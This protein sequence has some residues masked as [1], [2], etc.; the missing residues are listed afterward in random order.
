MIDVLFNSGTFKASYFKTVGSFVRRLSRWEKKILGEVE[1][2]IVGDEVIQILNKEYRGQ[3]RVTDV[4]SFAWQEDKK[5]SS[6]LLGQIFICYPQIKRQAKDYKVS[7]ES[8]FY[9]MLIHGLL[10]L[11]GY[12]HQNKA[13]ALKMFKKQDRILKKF[14]N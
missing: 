13:D 5:I 10:H 6:K 8:E 12:D 4:L 2:N 9:R 3:D 14:I 1:I 11:I 7:V